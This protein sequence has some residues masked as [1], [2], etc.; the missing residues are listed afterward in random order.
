MNNTNDFLSAYYISLLIIEGA[1]EEL[2]PRVA[3]CVAP[4]RELM[5]PSEVRAK[6][7]VTLLSAQRLLLQKHHAC[8][9]SS[10]PS[11]TPNVQYYFCAFFRFLRSQF[12]IL[13]RANIMLR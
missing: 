11:T 9:E 10:Q 13:H 3:N 1:N 5:Y 8:V 7:M 12:P 6:E 4:D 2:S